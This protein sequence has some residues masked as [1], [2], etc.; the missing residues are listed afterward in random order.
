MDIISQ[1]KDEVL[2]IN[3]EYINSSDD[4]FNFWEQH[5][6]YVVHEAIQ[7]AEK[8]NVSIPIIEQVNKV[9]FENKPADEAVREL[10]VR[11]KK[12]EYA[13]LPWE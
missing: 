3:N 5:I 11:D 4:N 8:Y 7:L 1:I 10:M 9:L 2:R 13:V 6:K 12:I